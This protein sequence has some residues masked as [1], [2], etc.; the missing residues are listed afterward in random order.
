ML[1]GEIARRHGG[2]GLPR[3]Q[4]RFRFTGSAGQSFGAFCARGVTLALEGEAN[5][6]VGKG[7]SG[8]RLVIRPPRGRG[9]TPPRRR[10]SATSPSTAPPRAS[11]TPPAGPASASRCATAGAAAV[12]EG[13]G[14]HGCEYMTGGV[15]VVLGRTGRNFA[16]GMSGGVAFVL[17]EDGTFARR[18]NTALVELGPVDDAADR[19]LLR[20]LVRRHYRL[21]ASPRARRVLQD[22]D[23]AAGRF[24]RV[25]PAEYRR[26]LEQRDRQPRHRGGRTTMG[27]PRA[28]LTHPPRGAAAAAGGAARH[29][30]DGVLRAR[31]A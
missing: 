7:L 22:W 5:D 29:D 31:T 9:S 3:G 6:H 25:M 19:R 10:C 21:T 11:S 4:V 14:D 12:V 18:C 24:V 27:D 17:D 13:V 23:A 26:A 30:L 8:G 20:Q 28:F 16:A 2:A 15:V 1:S